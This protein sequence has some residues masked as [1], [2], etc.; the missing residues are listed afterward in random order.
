MNKEQQ[1]KLLIEIMDA[2]EKDALYDK[3]IVKIL[4]H[5]ECIKFLKENGNIFY[6]GDEVYYQFP[7]YWYR[8]TKEENIFEEIHYKQN[9]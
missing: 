3:P 6:E 7:S 4:L 1:K 9:K 5:D 2:D 8:S